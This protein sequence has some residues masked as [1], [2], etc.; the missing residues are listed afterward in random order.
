MNLTPREKDKLLIAMAAMVARRRLERGVKLNHPEA[1]ALITDFILEGARDGKKRRRLDARRRACAHARASDGWHPRDDPRHP[2][3]G[4]VSRR[5]QA[6]HRAQSDPMKGRDHEK[7]VPIVSLSCLLAAGASACPCRRTA[8]PHRLPPARASARRA[9]P[10]RGHGGGRPV[11]GAKG[12]P[13]AVGLAGGFRR[14]D[15]GRRRARHGACAG[16]VRRAGHSRLGG[17]ARPAGGAGGRYAGRDRRYQSSLLL[18]CCTAMRMAAK[19]PRDERRRYMAGFRARNRRVA[20]D[21]ASALP[22]R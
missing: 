6:G 21:R 12:R 15:A 19:S 13:R 18:R 4:D 20:S 3:R 14:R 2:G 16:A 11:G 5:H 8:R 7:I 10:Y 22:E 17:R 1:V 9:R